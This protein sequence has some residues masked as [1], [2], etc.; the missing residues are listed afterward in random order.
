[1]LSARSMI[2]TRIEQVQH[3]AWHRTGDPVWFKGAGPVT[4]VSATRT[5]ETPDQVDTLCIDDFARDNRL[6]V[7]FIKMDIEGAELSALRGA[8]QTLR[9]DPPRLE[10]S[11]YHRLDDLALIPDYLLSLDLG[12]RL[13]LRSTTIFGAGLVLF[14][15]CP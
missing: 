11:A 13:H 3:P 6:T 2:F 5:P 4:R 12:Y 9:R 14:T 1:M 10:L 7:D 8:E 15:H